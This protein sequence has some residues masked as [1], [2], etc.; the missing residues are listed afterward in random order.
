LISTEIDFLS[1][2]DL[3]GVLATL[4]EHGD[5]VTVLSGGMSLMPMMNLG[6]AAPER[7]VSLRRVAELTSVVGEDDAVLIGAMVPHVAVMRHPAITAVAPALATAASR[8]GDV[9]VRNR[10]TI[11][12][13]VAHADPSADYLP[14]L[15]AHRGQIVLESKRDGKRLVDAADFFIDMMY[16]A[17]EPHELVTGVRLPRM[18]RRGAVSEYIRFARVE[19]SFAIVNAAVVLNDGGASRISVGGVGPAPVTL[20]ITD[21]GASGWDAAAAAAVGDAVFDACGDARGDIMS[22][23]EYRREMGR[24]HA[25]RVVLRAAEKLNRPN[26]DPKVVS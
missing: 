15:C 17:R 21:L 8:I 18:N 10:G 4:D 23:A 3:D 9:Q 22:D 1:P 16:T 6:L 24:V 26:T 14:C 5:D 7:V 13:S 25:R 12:G 20:D 19:G 2:D 11:G